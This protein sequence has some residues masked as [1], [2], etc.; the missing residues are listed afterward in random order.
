ML[1]LKANFH[2]R[3]QKIP[4]GAQNYYWNPCVCFTDIDILLELVR[5]KAG[6][7]VTFGISVTPE[8]HWKCPTVCWKNFLRRVS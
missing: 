8:I 4:L 2:F 6:R 5:L 3:R 7:I 1:E